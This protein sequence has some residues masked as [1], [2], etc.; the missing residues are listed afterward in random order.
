MPHNLA[1][2]V[3]MQTRS[4][5]RGSSLALVSA[6]TKEET[7]LAALCQELAGADFIII[8]KKVKTRFV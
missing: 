2:T 6:G 1:T 4:G 8:S 7:T 5:N 3:L